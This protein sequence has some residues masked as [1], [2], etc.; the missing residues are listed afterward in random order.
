MYPD[1]VNLTDF[2]NILFGL[3]NFSELIK[4]E[5]ATEILQGC[6]DNLNYFME[7]R[8]KYLLYK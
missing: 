2:A 8:K 4:N 1:K 6:Q 3:P 7:L 5:T